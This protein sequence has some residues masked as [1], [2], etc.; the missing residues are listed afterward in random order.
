MQT[1][2]LNSFINSLYRIIQLKTNFLY[3]KEAEENVIGLQHVGF[4]DVPFYA[5]IQYA[6]ISKLPLADTD[7]HTIFK[8]KELLSKTFLN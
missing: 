5:D 7:M 6:G 3:F 1:F 8:C 4:R 2:I